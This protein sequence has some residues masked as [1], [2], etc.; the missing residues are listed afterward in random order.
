MAD[1]GVEYGVAQAGIKNNQLSDCLLVALPETSKTAVL[2]TENHYLASP[3]I[4]SREHIKQEPNTRYLFINSGN[5]NCGLGASGLNVS[6]ETARTIANTQSCKTEQVLICSTGIINQPL[7][8]E[9]I[10]KGIALCQQNLGQAS[11]QQAAQAI[12]TTDTKAK[13]YR[14]EIQTDQGS[15]IIEGMAKGSGMI[16]PNMAT[17][18]G[19][20]FTDVAMPADLLK[21]AL[22][23]AAAHSFNRISVDG[24]T[25]TNDTLSLSA[26]G[27]GAL[28]IDSINSA[29][30][31]IW[32]DTL[33]DV[34]QALAKMIVK[35]GEGATKLIA[36]HVHEGLTEQECTQAAYTIG[37]SPLVKTAFF[38][39]DPNIGRI[40][41]ALG[42]SGIESLNF[43]HIDIYLGTV[44]IMLN[45]ELPANYDEN[46]AAQVMLQNEIDLTVHLRRGQASQTIWTCDF[47]YDYV[48]INAEYRT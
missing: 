6:K 9:K 31:Q 43:A 36:I 24:D 35:D 13:V 42:R 2:F 41:A 48:K 27:Q 39:Q 21:Q 8:L 12:M 22:T 44:P 16:C 46:Q 45:G 10:Q 15:F 1:L 19:F 5:A 37:H 18:L 11:I 17:M 30:W 40:A 7:P 4:V 14:R 32:L 47:S 20:V 38:A 23:K 29:H 34:C 3:V 26:T 25:S 33:I 28:S